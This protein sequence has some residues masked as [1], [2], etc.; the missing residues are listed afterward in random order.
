VYQPVLVLSFALG[1]SL[2]ATAVIAAAGLVRTKRLRALI[3]LTLGAVIAVAGCAIAKASLRFNFTPSI[4]LGVYR[5]TQVSDDGVQVGMLVVV[6]VPYRTAA[7]ARH[8]GYVSTG[9]CP[10][11]AEPL[12]KAVVAVD[13]D[14]VAVTV[15][16]IAVNG[17]L[18]PHSKPLPLDLAGRPLS[19]WPQGRYNLHTD[20]LW[21]YASNDRS[22]DSRYWG[23]VRTADVIA[24]ASSLLTFVSA[25]AP[26]RQAWLQCADPAAAH[27][28]QP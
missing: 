18:L 25:Y 5:V 28:R 16:G 26:E 1:I 22:W 10:A 11:H 13:G 14:E 7:L 4:S 21:L 24:T 12:L 23:P 9:Q 2:L 3:F 8:R 15:R 6:C 27:P 17:C 20:Q 19:A